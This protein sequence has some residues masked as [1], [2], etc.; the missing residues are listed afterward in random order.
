MKLPK[1]APALNL[2]I[3]NKLLLSY[4]ITI[5][6]PTLIVSWLSYQEYSNELADRKESAYK[7]D[8]KYLSKQIDMLVDSINAFSLQL[9]LSSEVNEVIASPENSMYRYN[10]MK[11]YLNTQISSNNL[12]YSAYLYMQVSDTVLTTNEGMFKR[13][14]FFDKHFVDQIQ[15]NRNDLSGYRLRTVEDSPGKQVEVF[16]FSRSIP[17]LNSYPLGQVIINV[18]KDRMMSVLQAEQPLKDHIVIYDSSHNIVFQNIGEDFTAKLQNENTPLWLEQPDRMEISIIDNKPYMT[19]WEKLN[20]INWTIVRLEPHSVFSDKLREK[21]IGIA[22]IDLIVFLAGILLSYLFAVF[23][24]HPWR[25]MIAGLSGYLK[26][27]PNV[28]SVGSSWVTEAVDDLIHENKQFQDTIRHY[29]PIIRDRFVSDILNKNYSPEL[30]IDEK[31]RGMGIAFDSPYFIVMIVS[32]DPRELVEL[33]EYEQKLLTYSYILNVMEREFP[34]I[35][36]VLESVELGYILNLDVP[37]LT[38]SMKDKLKVHCREINEWVQEELNTALQFSFGGVCD[39]IHN[40]SDSFEQARRVFRYKAVIH[41]ADTAFYD[42][43]SGDTEFV[44]PVTIQK[45]LLYSIVSARRDI[46]LQSIEDLF[47]NYIYKQ[48]VP[49]E[50]LQEMIVQLIITAKNKLLEE[51]VEFKSNRKNNASNVF[52]CS[53]SKELYSFMVQFINDLFEELEKCQDTKTGHAYIIKAVEYIE[54]HYMNNISIADIA[55]YLGISSSYLSRFFKAETG[56][57]PLEYLTEFRISKSKDLLKDSSYTLKEIS[58]K[59]GYNDVNSFIR[60]FKKYEG[61]TPGKYR[62]GPV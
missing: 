21:M 27:P 10:M 61:I 11:Q 50:S 46:A 4:L 7:E 39:S 54:I 47:N 29:E 48:K 41:Q 34:T 20:G 52:A 2:S 62:G 25:K 14:D 57:S 55:D 13:P 19:Y 35:G 43:M 51:G 12:F 5:L 37:D 53:N 22:K 9:S 8:L 32:S 56:K 24:Y 6:I 38:E 15:N 31:F 17:V 49:R 40:I 3:F 23:M 28:R 45:Q 42:E 60:Y 33:A 44:F 1:K 26:Q 36:T 58:E 18:R 16:T 30:N 59:I